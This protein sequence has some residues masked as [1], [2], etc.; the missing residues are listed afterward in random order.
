M[1]ELPPFRATQGQAADYTFTW[2][3]ANLTGH[4]GAVKLIDRSGEEITTGTATMNSAGEVSFSFTAEDT[5]DF[6]ALD[7]TGFF[8]VGNFQVKITGDTYNET[9][10]G[11]LAVAGEL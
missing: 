3:G 4:S 1:I 8:V 11:P 10:I 7:K 6:P 5:E 2:T 9:F